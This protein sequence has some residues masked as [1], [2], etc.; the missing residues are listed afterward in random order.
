MADWKVN[1]IRYALIV[2]G[3]KT[4]IRPCLNLPPQSRRRVTFS[5]RHIKKGAFVGFHARGSDLE[6][7]IDH[8]A[9]IRAELRDALTMVNVLTIAGASRKGTP[10]V[11]INASEAGLAA[12]VRW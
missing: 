1:V 5:A 2:H 4:E 12:A 11:Q 10:S 3:R 7:E 9:L 6:I 8:R